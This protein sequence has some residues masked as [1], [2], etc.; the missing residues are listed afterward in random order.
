MFKRKSLYPVILAIMLIVTCFTACSNKA[1]EE[2]PDND[3]ADMLP[4]PDFGVIDSVMTLDDSVSVS[5]K[6]AELNDFEN[7]SDECKKSGFDVEIKED[8]NEYSAF[9]NDGYGVKITY[10]K[11]AESLDIKLEKPLATGQLLWSE[12]G[13]ATKL[14]TP[15][16]T[17]GNVSNDS[18][19]Y[20]SVYVGDMS[21]DDYNKYVQSCVDMDYTA[22]YQKG[23]DYYYAN[24]LE[25]YHLT[26]NYKGFNTVL[27][28]IRVKDDINPDEMHSSAPEATNE[29]TEA[30]SE[31]ETQSPTESETEQSTD[32]SSDVSENNTVIRAEV[33][34]ALDSYEELMNEYCD[35]MQKC[36]E[37]PDDISLLID[38][39]DYMGKYTEAMDKLGAL[40]DVD[41]NDAELAY[42]LDV[43]NRINKRLLEIA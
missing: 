2:W 8:S 24:H 12:M 22:D 42:Y 15:K 38:Y 36:S 30:P 26:L 25:G 11:S 32:A 16:S 29:P 9:N 17:L 6:N 35:F 1:K 34:E 4:K 14:P 5:V 18:E 41:L 33:K 21:V 13:L 27:I 20:F 28:T 40:D 39:A 3:L 43:T 23:D 10:Y 7:Y 37:N 19:T 31:N